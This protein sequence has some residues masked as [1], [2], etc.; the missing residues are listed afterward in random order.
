MIIT[1]EQRVIIMNLRKLIN[2]IDGGFDGY[3]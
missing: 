3:G 1:E 2:E